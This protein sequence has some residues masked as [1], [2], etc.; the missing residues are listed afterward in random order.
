MSGVFIKRGKLGY[1]ERRA[2]KKFAV[3]RSSDIGV[4]T[5]AL[6][7]Q[8]KGPPHYWKLGGASLAPQRDM[9]LPAAG[10]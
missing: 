2:Q 8:A 10:V 4:R 7:F 3:S 1:R 6:H 9:A 5:G